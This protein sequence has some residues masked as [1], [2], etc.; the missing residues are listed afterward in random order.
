MDRAR[1]RLR[2]EFEAFDLDRPY[3]LQFGARIFDYDRERG[4]IPLDVGAF[5]SAFAKD[6]TGQSAGF[7]LRLRNAEAIGVVPVAD[8]D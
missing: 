8:A 7:L 4:G 3:T 6:P 1:R 2:S 5:R